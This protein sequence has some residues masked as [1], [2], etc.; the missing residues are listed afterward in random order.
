[1]SRVDLLLA[2]DSAAQQQQGNIRFPCYHAV[3]QPV[4]L[5]CRTALLLVNLSRQCAWL[6]TCS[7]LLQRLHVFVPVTALGAAQESIFLQWYQILALHLIHTGLDGLV[8]AT[9]A[10]SQQQQQHRQ[11]WQQQPSHGCCNSSDTATFNFQCM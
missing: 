11:Q 2:V 6:T 4:A 5:T 9:T 10:Q 3:L 8:R 7:P 1:M